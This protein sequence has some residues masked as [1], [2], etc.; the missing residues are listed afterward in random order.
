MRDT[1]VIIIVLFYLRKIA[2]LFPS[3]PNLIVP[4]FN[5]LTTLDMSMHI[6]L[7]FVFLEFIPEYRKKINELRKKI[8]NYDKKE[9]NH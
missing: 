1:I 9:F 8:Y 6:A 3:M 4:S 2:L 7:I 5:P